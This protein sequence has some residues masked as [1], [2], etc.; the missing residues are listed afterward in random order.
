MKVKVIVNAVEDRVT[1]EVHLK[2]DIFDLPDNRALI[3]IAHEY[4]EAVKNVRTRK[5]S[6][7]DND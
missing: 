2:G 1:G 7:K 4:V 5:V 3:A 6:I